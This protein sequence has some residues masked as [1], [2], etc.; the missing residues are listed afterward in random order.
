VQRT[1][2]GVA[3]SRAERA[4][5]TI[6]PRMTLAALDRV[7]DSQM[8]RTDG[9]T[10][11]VWCI[12][13][14]AIKIARHKVGARCNLFEASFYRNS[15]LEMRADLCPVLWCSDNGAVLVM[16][17]AEPIREDEFDS[18]FEN[19]RIPFLDHI[20]DKDSPFEW[21]PSDLGWLDGRIVALDYSANVALGRA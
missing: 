13:S 14:I 10:R 5:V 4:A 11:L 2:L 6:A 18:L 9:K 17:R 3:Q 16:P 20:H 19:G 21:K 7:T 15:S 8:I 1:A 12:G